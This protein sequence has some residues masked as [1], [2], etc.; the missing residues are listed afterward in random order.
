M[1]K[2]THQLITLHLKKQAHFHICNLLSA[3]WA[4]VLNI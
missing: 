4:S 1:K 3:F 2:A